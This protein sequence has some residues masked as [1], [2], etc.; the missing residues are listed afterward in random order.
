MAKINKVYP[1]FFNGVSQQSPELVLDNQCKEMINCIPDIVKGITKRPPVTYVTH[2]DFATYPEMENASVFHTYDRGEDNEEYIMVNV[3]DVDNPIQIFNKAGE[4]QKVFYDPTN[5]AAIKAYLDNKALKGLTVQDRTWV[6][7]KNATVGLNFDATSP[8][9]STYDREAYYW[10]KRGS[11]DRFNPFNYAVYLDGTTFSVDPEKP[12]TVLVAG[13]GTSLTNDPPTGAEDSDVAASLLAAKINASS[14]WNC[15]RSGSILRIT[16][17]DGANFTFSSWDSWGNQASEGWKGSVNKLSDLPK[18]M[19][20]SNVYVKILGDES[21]TFTDY[22]VK[23]NGSSWEE[24]LDPEADRGQLINMPIK[25][26]RT[27][28]YSS[29]FAEVFEAL[30][31]PETKRFIRLKA[32]E[33]SSYTT[34]YNV[35]TQWELINDLVFNQNYSIHGLLK[36]SVGAFL[37][38]EDVNAYLLDTV[39]PTNTVH[40]VMYEYDGSLSGV[41]SKSIKWINTIAGFTLNTIDWSLPRVGNIENNPDPSFVGRKIQDLFFYKNRLGIASE[42]SISMTE[43]ANYTNFYVTTAVDIVDTDVIDITLSSN[44]A[45]KIYYAKPFNNSLYIFTKYSQYELVSEGVFSPSTVALNNTTNYPMA[46]DVEPVVINDRLLFIST[47]NNRQQLRE[48]IKSD[49]LNVTG[50]DLNV[51]TPTYMEKQISKIIVDGVLG[52]VLCCT[53]SGTIY[54]YNFKEDGTQRIQSSW[55]RWELYDNTPNHS[56]YEWFNIGSTVLVMYKE[57]ADGKYVYSNLVLDNVENITYQDVSSG[58]DTYNYS[59]S[60]LLPDYYPQLGTVRTPLNKMLIKRVK[61]EG[62]GAFSGTVYR[63]DYD[64]TYVK[65]KDYSMKD[66]DLNVASKVGNVDITIYDDSTDNFK[67][68]SVVVEGLFNTT[69][70]EMR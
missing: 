57:V 19:P 47:T 61:V 44:Q 59:S 41:H 10:I 25:L 30:Y 26:D 29:Q 3:D 31:Y 63:K 55:S 11:G 32:P 22:F 52:Y 37:S 48:Y 14:T 58:T 40:V 70:K 17:A 46:I 36:N 20:F 62:E 34:W 7:S 15:S 43:T 9:K 6:F 50:I 8:L 27:G 4:P 51:S 24:C 2:K 35:D 68:T 5:E 56:N 18:D 66:L 53:S 54:F 38:Y 33:A 45:S 60:I 13:D 1:A 64:K 65:S 28:L 49:N 42:D 23:W 12:P 16:R 21:N 39:D 69:S 67:I